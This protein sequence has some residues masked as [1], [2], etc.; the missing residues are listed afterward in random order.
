MQLAT[1]AYFYC[2]LQ[3]VIRQPK[4]PIMPLADDNPVPVKEMKSEESAKIAY[5][6]KLSSFSFRYF[7]DKVIQ[8]C[9]CKKILFFKYMI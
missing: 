3:D 5:E 6:I 7:T 2:R 1:N 8:L 9:P 4:Y